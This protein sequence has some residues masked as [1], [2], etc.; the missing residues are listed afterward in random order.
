VN[1]ALFGASGFIGGYL[2]K[3]LIDQCFHPRILIRSGSESK[4]KID[5]GRIHSFYGDLDSDRSVRKVLEHS[6][7]VIYNI[8]I[9]REFKSKGI[10]FESIHFDGLKKVVDA[11]QDLNIKRFILMSAN[12]IEN[13]STGY[14]KSKLKAE[15]YLKKSGLDWTIFRP[16]LVFGESGPGMAEFCLDLKRKMIRPPIPAP[17]FFRGFSV[18]SSGSFEMSPIHASDVAK[19]FVKSLAMDKTFSRTYELGGPSTVSWK[20]IIKNI[21]LAM[22]KKR[23]LVIPVPASQVKLIAAI[24]DRFSWFPITRDQITMLLQG[25][26]CDSSEHYK[27]FDIDPIYFSVENLDYLMSA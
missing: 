19:F 1:V 23:K 14:Q 11:A 18:I 24:F 21:A 7:A 6:D 5:K 27:E 10:T 15:E 2:L 22:G 26:T 16:S 3:E 20:E 8:G 12:G 9:I 13:A 4:I 17:L 25:N